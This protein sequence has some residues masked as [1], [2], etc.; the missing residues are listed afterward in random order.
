MW[1]HSVGILRVLPNSQKEKTHGLYT[2]TMENIMT[3]IMLTVIFII[4]VIGTMFQM[5]FKKDE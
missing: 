1:I 3:T 5:I 2:K 4:A